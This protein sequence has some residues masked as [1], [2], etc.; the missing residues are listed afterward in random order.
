MGNG[1]KRETR[2]NE[3]ISPEFDLMATPPS[4]ELTMGCGIPMMSRCGYSK[5]KL[6]S[7]GPMMNAMYSNFGFFHFFLN[8]WKKYYLS[9]DGVGLSIFDT[10]HSSKPFHVIPVSEISFVAILAGKPTSA[11]SAPFEDTHDVVLKTAHHETIFLRFS[12]IGTRVFWHEVFVSC[13][14]GVPSYSLTQIDSRHSEEDNDEDDKG[15][16]RRIGSVRGAVGGAANAT[17]NLVRG[18][19]NLVGGGVK[20]FVGTILPGAF[21]PG[22]LKK[23]DAN[24]SSNPPP[25]RSRSSF[26]ADEIFGRI[27]E[28]SDNKSDHDLSRVSSGRSDLSDDF[29]QKKEKRFVGKYLGASRDSSSGE[30]D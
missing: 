6:S 11:A 19:A 9:L 21:I 18:S 17:E 25:K 23:H 7:N 30:S 15:F 2:R 16:L 24:E 5:L 22:F 4:M 12:D 28:I 13:I 14:K 26:V 20:N 29:P 8:T 1:N 10:K 27:N 3:I